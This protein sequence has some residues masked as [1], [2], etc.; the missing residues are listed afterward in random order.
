M[1]T[2]TRISI[3]LASL[4]VFLMTLAASAA[5]LPERV[6]THFNWAGEADGWMSRSK[7]LMAFGAF[8]VLFSA[9]FIGIFYS[10]RFLPPSLLNVSN[11]EYWRSPEHY[12]EACRFMFQQ[13]F[14][15]ATIAS[16]FVTGLNL[17]VVRANL[18]KE[19][20][21]ELTPTLILG[22]VFLASMLIWVIRLIRFF[23]KTDS[24]GP[25]SV[26]M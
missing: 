7:H 10:I 6:A 26:T 12:P 11:P 18:P 9:F 14:F 20:S 24:T 13:S 3:W 8:G 22:G 21:M 1:N 15:V 25:T 17:L 23:G 19:P 4:T 5:W 16:V 2:S